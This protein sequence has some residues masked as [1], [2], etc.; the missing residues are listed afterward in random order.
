MSRMSECAVSL[1]LSLAT[2][3]GTQAGLYYP[4]SNLEK[5]ET[6]QP[7]NTALALGLAWEAHAR[8]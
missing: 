6:Y 3:L 7:P 8:A 1:T 5:G 4:H 2:D